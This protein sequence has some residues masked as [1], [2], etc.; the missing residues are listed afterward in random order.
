[1]CYEMLDGVFREDDPKL[2]EK[3]SHHV[4]AALCGVSEKKRCWCCVV[5]SK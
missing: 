3:L 5:V 1:M 4:R 2:V